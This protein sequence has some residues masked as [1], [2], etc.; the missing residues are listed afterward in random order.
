[1]CV[2]GR[3][4][5]VLTRWCRRPV[6]A[7]RSSPRRPPWGLR[8]FRSEEEGA[9]ER[10]YREQRERGYRE[11]CLF[12]TVGV[13]LQVAIEVT[14]R[15]TP[16]AIGR[17]RGGGI[18]MWREDVIRADD[19]PKRTAQRMAYGAAAEEAQS[20]RE[21]G[22]KCSNGTTNGHKWGRIGRTASGGP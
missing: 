10:G 14:S 7:A 11:D 17:G 8:W 1:M 16:V 6:R 18:S 2:A 12:L 21:P 19:R 20:K 9:R 13:L 22:H 4:C 5:R 15:S 3:V